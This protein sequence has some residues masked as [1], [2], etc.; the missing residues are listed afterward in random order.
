VTFR[1]LNTVA[2]VMAASL[3]LAWLFAPAQYLM[4]WSL[5]LTDATAV[6]MRRGGLLFFAFAVLLFLTRDFK[7][8]PERNAV[9][10]ALIAGCA[11]LAVQAMFEFFSGHAGPGAWGAVVVEVGLTASY[12][13]VLGKPA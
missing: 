7:A 11:A 5:P 6:M 9:C 1:V 2:A 12:L 8:G 3:T 13:W 4:L 10:Y